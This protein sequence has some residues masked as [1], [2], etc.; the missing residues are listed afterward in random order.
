MTTLDQQVRL[1][2]GRLLGYDEYG[3]PGGSPLLYLHGTPGAR[4]EWRLFGGE[5][6]ARSL[7][8]RIIAVDRPGMGLSDF[9]PG[10][11]VT[12][13]PGDVLALA[14]RLRIG[15][16]AVLGCSGGGPY[17]AACGA[18][19]KDR[20]TAVGMVAGLAPFE[21]G[22]LAGEVGGRARR[23][24]QLARDRPAVCRALLR[25][26]GVVASRY[27]R[28]LTRRTRAAPDRVLMADPEVQQAFLAEVREALRTGA[29]GAQHD[30]ALLARPWGF[31]L[32]DIRAPVYI[33]HGEQDRNVPPQTSRRLAAAI[34]SSRTRFYPDEAHLSL[35]RHHAGEILAQLI[36]GP[37]S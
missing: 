19:L 8:L 15:A 25:L 2:D 36:S 34:P 23:F 31:R 21:D 9:Q 17:A 4:R 24:L 5:Q 10:R 11:R 16:F 37:P 32:E 6:A 28:M 12:D 27:P 1:P 20:V 35:M 7:D 29:R 3:V 22:I 33:W 26:M 14:D 18:L 30:A 13:W